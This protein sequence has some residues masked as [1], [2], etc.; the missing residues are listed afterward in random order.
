MFSVGGTPSVLGRAVSRGD[1]RGMLSDRGVAPQR[2]SLKTARGN[3][4]GSRRPTT[5]ANPGRCPGLACAAPNPGRCP[6]LACA[7]PLALPGSSRH[8]SSGCVGMGAATGPDMQRVV[9]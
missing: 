2:G 9:A 7:A 5:S 4:P 8:R 6:G 3:A 1:C